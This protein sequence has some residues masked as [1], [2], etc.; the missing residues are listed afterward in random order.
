MMTKAVLYTV[1][2]TM[3]ITAFAAFGQETEKEVLRTA[4]S[5]LGPIV[6]SENYAINVPARVE[7]AVTSEAVGGIKT[8]RVGLD[9]LLLGF[10]SSRRVGFPPITPFDEAD[11]AGEAIDRAARMGQVFGENSLLYL[12]A[13]GVAVIALI[14]YLKS[15]DT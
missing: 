5:G 14:A 3:F 10:G 13:V 2:V 12:L 11:D 15:L 8:A 4:D 6:A 7:L 1:L 9:S